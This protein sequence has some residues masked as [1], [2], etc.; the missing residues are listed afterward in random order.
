MRRTLNPMLL[1]ASA[2]AFL[3]LGYTT[4]AFLSAK[5]HL[6]VA[7][8]DAFTS[9][10]ALRQA[11]ALVYGANSDESR[12]LLDPFASKHEQAFFNKIA[13][14]ATLPQGASFET[15]I[16][17]SNKGEKVSGFT[18]YLADQLNNITFPGEREA[19]VASMR[20]LADYVTIDQ[21][22]RQLKQSGKLQ[23][24]IALCIGSN[25]GESNWA[26]K[27]FLDANQKNYDINDNAFKASIEQGFRDLEGF[28]IKTIIVTIAIASLSLFGL[29]P[30]LKEYDN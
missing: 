14:V 18:G 25:T 15:V 20:V 19:T 2:I 4:M 5:N 3:F 27:Q 12:Y 8:E 24:A 13:K 17:A 16:E 6:K 7:K 29:R 9:M 10:H 11:R 1:A 23:E 21:K 26:F 30:R 22:I 28:E